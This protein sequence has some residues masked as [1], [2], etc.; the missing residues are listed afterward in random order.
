MKTPPWDRPLA[1]LEHYAEAGGPVERIPLLTLPFTIGRA[2]HAGYRIYSSQ[3]SKEHAAIVM[4]GDHYAVRDLG[5]TNGTF[6]NGR[7]TLEEVLED[8]DIIHVAH[9]EFSFRCQ[10]VSARG[11]K[12]SEAIAM[13]RT[14][15]ID[16]DQPESVIRGTRL[17][18]EMIRDEACEILYQPIVDL[19]SRT[20]MGY[21]ALCRGQHPE[22]TASPAMLLRLAEQCGLVI[23]LS[24]MLARLAVTRSRSLPVGMKLFI[25]LHSRELTGPGLDQSLSA[26]HELVSDD[27][28]IVLEIPES[29][30]TDVARMADHKKAFA[31]LG[32][33]FAYDDFGAGQ[34]RLIELTDVP[35]HYL[36]FDRS[37]IAGIHVAKSRREMVGAL[38]GAMKGLGV[39]VIAE[40]IESEDVATVCQELGC[41]L[42]QGFLFGRPA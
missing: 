34:A 20:V 23:G 2:E 32:F 42:G 40:G 1:Y 6:V 29:S 15:V 25:N 35:P 27:R 7:R 18:R 4:I 26:L 13:E 38:L 22:L 11:L 5:S 28:P 33:E 12:T 17:L 21:E 39:Q 41:D 8:G 3:V 36:K 37:I 9:V 19:G 24:Q 31:R 16:A 30:I 14:Q 10:K